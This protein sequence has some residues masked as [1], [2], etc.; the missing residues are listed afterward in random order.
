MAPL[1]ALVLLAPA[2]RAAGTAAVDACKLLKVRELRNVLD[3]PVARPEKS[4][5]SKVIATCEWQVSA[6]A[7]KPDGS[8]STFLQF[9]GA[10][11]SF[12]TNRTQL[13][14]S[15]SSVS[16]L[17]KHA[18]YQSTGTGGGVVWVLKGKV[19]L[20]VQG[21]FVSAPDGPVANAE[22]LE[23]ELVAAARIAKG[24]F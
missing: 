16:G 8:V 14:K 20:T 19:L 5:T 12:D 23:H 10:K 6:T 9:V 18:F 21:V 2:A 7:N 17:G 24:R 15:V 11:I 1:V 3:Q 13:G 22:E 4:R